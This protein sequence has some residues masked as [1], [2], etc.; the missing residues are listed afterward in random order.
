MKIQPVR[1]IVKEIR[2]TAEI[3]E[4]CCDLMDDLAARLGLKQITMMTVCPYCGVF[5][6]VMNPTVREIEADA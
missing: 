4:H 1:V 3:I 2:Q 6:Q 5:I